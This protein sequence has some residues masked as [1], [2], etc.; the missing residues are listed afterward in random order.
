M[1]AIVQSSSVSLH[2]N[3]RSMRVAEVISGATRLPLISVPLFLVVGVA[4][5]GGSGFFWALFCL[6]LTSGLSM[7]Y[8]LHLMRSG[9]VSDPRRIS[10]AERVGPLRV[11]AGLHAGAFA[12]LALLEAPAAL[13]AVLLSYAISTVLFAL[14]VPVTNLSLHAAGVSGAAVCLVFVFG[15]WGVLGA[16][17]IPPVLWTRSVLKRHT[18]LELLI[19]LLVGGGG[20]WVAFG[21]IG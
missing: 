1:V 6:L 4:V 9:K 5:G 14:I 13:Q 3:K 20:T 11:V 15:A 7:L 2:S 17:L 18:P 21:L 12:I 19:G 16:L 8:L 10:Q